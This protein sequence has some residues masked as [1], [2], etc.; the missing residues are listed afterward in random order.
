[1][2][3]FLL[4]VLWVVA[5][6]NISGCGEDDQWKKLKAQCVD[7]LCEVVKRCSTKPLDYDKCIS[8][9]DAFDKADTAEEYKDLFLCREECI[10]NATTPKTECICFLAPEHGGPDC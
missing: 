2:K 4:V 8:S 9:C 3:R 6:G 10:E 7:H 1:M 5:A